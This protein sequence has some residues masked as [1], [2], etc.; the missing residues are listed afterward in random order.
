MNFQFYV[1]LHFSSVPDNI[2]TL[3]TLNVLALFQGRRVAERTNRQLKQQLANYKV[4]DVMEYI[5][6][7]ADLYELQKQVK[8]WKRKVDIAS[9]SC[10]ANLLLQLIATLLVIV[11]SLRMSVTIN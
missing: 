10:L 11:R 9:V 7:K 3:D 5:K 2:C 8:S 1:F 6:E 4:P